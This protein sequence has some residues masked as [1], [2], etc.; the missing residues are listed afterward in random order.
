MS[1]INWIGAKVERASQKPN[2]TLA[3]VMRLFT[4]RTILIYAR[5][6]TILSRNLRIKTDYQDSCQHTDAVLTVNPPG[7]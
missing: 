3:P 7:N 1:T 6:F 5:A 4:G 2:A